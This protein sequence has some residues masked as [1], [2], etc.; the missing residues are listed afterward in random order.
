MAMGKLASLFI[1]YATRR[2]V[3]QPSLAAA[4]VLGSALAPSHNNCESKKEKKKCRTGAG[5]F[6]CAFRSQKDAKT[7]RKGVQDKSQRQRRSV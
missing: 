7:G 5:L 6:G 4:A 3:A 2:S 1:M